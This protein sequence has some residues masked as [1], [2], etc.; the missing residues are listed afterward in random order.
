MKKR[1][2]AVAATA[3]IPGADTM[4]KVTDAELRFKRRTVLAGGRDWLSLL[5]APPG[6]LGGGPTVWL[7]ICGLGVAYL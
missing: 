4:G 6:R 3:A 1:K 5:A 7:R 2:A